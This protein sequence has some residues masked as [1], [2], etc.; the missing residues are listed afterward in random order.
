ME[1]PGSRGLGVP[2]P[3]PGPSAESGWD[4]VASAWSPLWAQP[5]CALSLEPTV[6]PAAVC[7]PDAPRPPAQ[8]LTALEKDEQA[9]RQR[10][11]SRL[12]Q[13]VD[14]MALSS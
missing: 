7:Y 8:I 5:L 1:T 9:R 11:R 6:D 10:L 14:T 2:A 4:K 13:V 3:G 12:E